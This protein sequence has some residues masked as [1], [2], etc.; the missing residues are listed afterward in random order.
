MKEKRRSGCDPYVRA[1]GTRA[2]QDR[3]KQGRVF[4]KTE[5]PSDERADGECAGH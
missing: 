2:F 1:L 4:L 3:K 5:R